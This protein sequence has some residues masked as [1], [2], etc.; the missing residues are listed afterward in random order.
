M[1]QYPSNRKILDETEYV[2]NIYYGDFQEDA[3]TGLKVIADAK[4][5]KEQNAEQN[6]ED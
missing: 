1:L 2:G 5:A 6:I 4:A 3:T